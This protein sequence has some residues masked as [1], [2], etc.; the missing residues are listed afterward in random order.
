MGTAIVLIIFLACL[1]VLVCVSC[2]VNSSQVDENESQMYEK[3]MQES[4]KS[5]GN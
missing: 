5:E 4:Q 2:I 3:F 1:A